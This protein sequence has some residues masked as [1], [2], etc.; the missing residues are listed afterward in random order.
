MYAG[1]GERWTL[2]YSAINELI[3]AEYGKGSRETADRIIASQNLTD[4]ELLEYKRDFE[5]LMKDNEVS[6]I[7]RGET[8]EKYRPIL[9]S[10]CFDLH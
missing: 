8:K 4:E 2:I 5:V 10:T 9:Y 1:D 6:R 3:K 7:A